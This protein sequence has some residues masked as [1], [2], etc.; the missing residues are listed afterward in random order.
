MTV[1]FYHVCH[2]EDR[3]SY[4]KTR[5]KFLKTES[6]WRTGEIL[7]LSDK[8]L[9]VNQTVMSWKL[10][11]I[12]QGFAA[13]SFPPSTHFFQ[14]KA[15]IENSTIFKILQKMPKGMLGKLIVV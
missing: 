2:C 5:Q 10:A 15:L 3:S 4:I 13:G 14:A 8:E 9:K 12:N 7:Y 1:V 6:S 11:E